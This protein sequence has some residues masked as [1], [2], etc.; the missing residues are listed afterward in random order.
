MCHGWR[1]GQWCL[2][3]T[4]GSISRFHFFVFDLTYPTWWRCKNPKT[5]T[6]LWG[7][8]CVLAFCH[9]KYPIM[10]ISHVCGLRQMVFSHMGFLLAHQQ[11]IYLPVEMLLHLWMCHSTLAAST[12]FNLFVEMLKF[13]KTKIWEGKERIYWNT[14]EYP[15]LDMEYLSLI[16]YLTDMCW[17]CLCIMVIKN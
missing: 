3:S 5:Q 9:K 4:L 2:W 6:L 1:T 8:R 16:N 14:Q 15:I 11:L 12:L 10:F 7:C 13:Q 17:S